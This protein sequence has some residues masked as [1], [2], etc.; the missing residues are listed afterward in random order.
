MNV[1]VLIKECHDLQTVEKLPSVLTGNLERISTKK[2]DE[3]MDT[4][5]GSLMEAIGIVF[6]N[7]AGN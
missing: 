3:A 1:L 7:S 4:Q 5:L 6:K 2:S